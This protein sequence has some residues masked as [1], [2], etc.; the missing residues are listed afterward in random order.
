MPWLFLTSHQHDPG[1]YGYRAAILERRY[2]PFVD[3]AAA[4]TDA[5][6]ANAQ[7][8]CVCDSDEAMFTT[9]ICPNNDGVAVGGGDFHRRY[10]L[11]QR[12]VATPIDDDDSGMTSSDAE[13]MALR[14]ARDDVTLVHRRLIR[15]SQI[16][17]LSV[18]TD[19]Y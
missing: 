4:D 8:Y 14:F 13:A 17:G 10:R 11:Y 2:P 18:D 7:A 5:D 9:P 6:T 3:A 12:L 1:V 19:V 16:G 15:R